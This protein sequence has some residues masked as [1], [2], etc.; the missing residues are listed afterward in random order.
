M[1][2]QRASRAGNPFGGGEIR[3]EGST[4][5]D[6]S[7]FS[8]IGAGRVKVQAQLTPVGRE[9]V[10]VSCPRHPQHDLHQSIVT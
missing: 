2:G 4:G 1:E 5:C 7:Y 8:V 6:A 10:R 9:M 3:L